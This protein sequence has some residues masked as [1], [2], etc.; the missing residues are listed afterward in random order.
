MKFRRQIEIAIHHLG[1]LGGK[2]LDHDRPSA[3]HKTR[4]KICVRTCGWHVRVLW[5]IRGQRD[6]RLRPRS[7]PEILDTWNE[8][9]LRSA[10]S[11]ELTPSADFQNY[12]SAASAA[13]PCLFSSR[14]WCPVSL[15]HSSIFISSFSRLPSSSS[16][17]FFQ[18][19]HNWNRTA[20]NNTEAASIFGESTDHGSKHWTEV[21]FRRC[22]NSEN[23][24]EG[25]GV[26]KSIGKLVDVRV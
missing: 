21:R 22:W 26:L 18:F 19:L 2:T 9:N 13:T 25:I 8:A 4:G 20:W 23:S 14:C 7:L 10:S 16:R 15:F 24:W 12:Y 17:L 6:D 5:S 1:P 11:V 3:S